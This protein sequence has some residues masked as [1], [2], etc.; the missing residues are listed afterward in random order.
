MFLFFLLSCQSEESK[1][2]VQDERVVVGKQKVDVIKQSLNKFPPNPK[3]IPSKGMGGLPPM[4]KGA[5]GGA[6]QDPSGFPNFHDWPAPKGPSVSQKG[7]WSTG[8]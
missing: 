7:G 1:E 5:S 8:P 4:K 3:N 2:P 6:L